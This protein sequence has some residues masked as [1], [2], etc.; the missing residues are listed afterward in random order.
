MT[1]AR[2][3]PGLAVPAVMLVAAWLFIPFFSSLPPSLAGIRTYGV[4]VVLALGLVISLAFRRGRIVFALLMLF[5]AHGCYALLL[6]RGLDGFPARTVFVFLTLFLPFNFAALALLPERGTFTVYGLRR[7]A[8]IV[9]EA[10]LTG[11]IVLA[12][13]T[14]ITAWTSAPLFDTELFAWSPIPQLGLAMILL[15][16]AICLTAWRFKRSPL[17]LGL[18]AAGLAFGIGMNGIVRA[19]VFPVFIMA[20]GLMLIV[21]VLQ[22]TYRMAFHDELTG[23]PSRRDLNESM[24]KLGRCYTIAMLDVDHFKNFN[25]T[26]GHDLGDQVLKI[27]ARKIAEAGG[28]SKPYRYGGEEFTL[29]F[30]GKGIDEAIP[31]LEALRQAIADYKLALRKADRPPEPKAGTRKR[32]AFRTAKSIS[33]TISIGVAERTEKLATPAAVVKAA[34]KALYRAKKMGRNQVSK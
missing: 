22:T 24:M 32:G 6:Q 17:D 3:V 30:P 15:S 31:H 13:K 8:I 23:L 10:A 5:C 28:G 4:P 26:Y 2:L 16:V 20:A 21:A 7:L 1:S 25:D 9:V 29:L 34:D 33:V 11:W 18:A 14:E 19:N 27:V 12:A